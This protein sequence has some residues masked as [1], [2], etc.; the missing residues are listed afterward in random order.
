MLRPWPL[1]TMRQEIVIA[2]LRRIKGP[3]LWG[4]TLVKTHHI[5]PLHYMAPKG[6]DRMSKIKD[7]KMEKTNTIIPQTIPELWGM[8][9]YITLVVIAEILFT[10][11]WKQIPFDISQIISARVRIF[12]LFSVSHPLCF[13]ILPIVRTSGTLFHGFLQTNRGLVKDWLL[14]LQKGHNKENT[15]I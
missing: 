7:N 8:G 2:N 11:L 13:S 15:F 1:E 3:L 6:R 4:A 9:F 10:Q 5:W 14:V 12:I